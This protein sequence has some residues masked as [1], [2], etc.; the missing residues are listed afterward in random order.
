MRDLLSGEF[1]IESVMSTAA[2][3]PT[4][5]LEA[6]A[7]HIDDPRGAE[8]FLRGGVV[9]SRLNHL[10][11]HPHALTFRKCVIKKW[12]AATCGGQR[13]SFSV[14][15][16]AYGATS[17]CNG[18]L[19]PTTAF[20]FAEQQRGPTSFEGLK[21]R[22]KLEGVYGK[23]KSAVLLPRSWLA[24]DELLNSIF[25]EELA[26]TQTIK[27]DVI[28]VWERFRMSFEAGV[29]ALGTTGNRWIMRYEHSIIEHAL[30]AMPSAAMNENS[31]KHMIDVVARAYLYFR[32]HI[33]I[34]AAGDASAAPGAFGVC[35]SNAPG[36]EDRAVC[37]GNAAATFA[38]VIRRVEKFC[39][40]ANHYGNNGTFFLGSSDL[41]ESVHVL[42]GEEDDTSSSSDAAVLAEFRA[43][44]AP[45]LCY[46]ARRVSSWT[47]VFAVVIG[48]APF[49][50]S[51]RATRWLL[52][53]FVPNTLRKRQTRV[54]AIWAL[55]RKFIGKSGSQSHESFE[56]HESL[57]WHPYHT[58]LMS[59][60]QRFEN[61]YDP[62]LHYRYAALAFRASDRDARALDR[63]ERLVRLFVD[64]RLSFGEKGKEN[65][66]V[67]PPASAT[68]LQASLAFSLYAMTCGSTKR[69]GMIYGDIW[70]HRDTADV[71]DK[72]IKCRRLESAA[73][74][75]G[76]LYRSRSRLRSYEGEIDKT[77][78]KLYSNRDISFVLAVELLRQR[79]RCSGDDDSY[80]VFR[81][82]FEAS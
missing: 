11:N 77:I 69:N 24:D 81:K 67:G 27:G 31:G 18:T 3:L 19:S 54:R 76:H 60:Q 38:A 68:L 48:H 20:P 82:H 43:W 45:A 30:A 25:L 35:V 10:R 71:D 47:V 59:Q 44:L 46:L 52:F 41:V 42:L 80:A 7:W 8:A 61:M 36:A 72:G 40:F 32:R 56:S 15:F 6:I 21:N 22:M 33:G 28:D 64:T 29:I 5:V 75:L 65:K 62:E 1:S 12:A 2:D 34:M 37:V 49:G 39:D 79:Y 78:D 50:L 16:I 26:S 13:C 51:V 9:H 17:P 53:E 74:A 63:C 58:M 55:I 23:G 73:N 70:Y 57:P 66:V 14:P 4:N